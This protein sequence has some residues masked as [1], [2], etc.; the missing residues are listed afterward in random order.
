MIP[1]G[2]NVSSKASWGCAAQSRG[3]RQAWDG[4]G[5]EGDQ[6]QSSSC[7]NKSGL[8]ALAEKPSCL[9]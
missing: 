8:A 2:A 6:T 7:W 4:A 3:K 5:G 1:Q 9:T